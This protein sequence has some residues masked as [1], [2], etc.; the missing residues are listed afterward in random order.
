MGK[1]E[2]RV[3]MTTLISTTILLSMLTVIPKVEATAATSLRPQT[4]EQLQNCIDSG[5]RDYVQKNRLTVD[6]NSINQT[7]AKFLH[8]NPTYRDYL[9]SYIN[10]SRPD[11][12]NAGL[13]A[14]PTEVVSVGPAF[15][16]ERKVLGNITYEVQYKYAFLADGR[17][18]TKIE[19][20][21][22]G[23]N[24]IDPYIYA[25]VDYIYGYMYGHQVIL[26]ETDYFAIG[27]PND[28]PTT[29]EDD[30]AV[31]RDYIIGQLT[32]SQLFNV[33]VHEGTAGAIGVAAAI[34]GAA[35]VGG[36][37]IAP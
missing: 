15:K 37:A 2:Y 18:I 13:P 9:N 1:K 24:D 7:F 20:H 3:L 31:M 32:S 33:V 8:Q 11:I 26:G 14:L 34:A 35:V 22:N 10:L 4:K 5:F 25:R 27:Y 30:A 21:G 29:H 23:L 36:V 28:N 6:S 16:T 19:F 12:N 17:Q